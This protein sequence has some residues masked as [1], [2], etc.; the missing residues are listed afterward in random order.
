MKLYFFALFLLSFMIF[1]I[2]NCTYSQRDVLLETLKFLFV[3]N[4]RSEFSLNLLSHLLFDSLIKPNSRA[5]WIFGCVFVWQIVFFSCFFG[6]VHVH[7][8]H[9]LQVLLLISA[10]F[11]PTGHKL[12]AIFFFFATTSLINSQRSFHLS[13]H[14]RVIN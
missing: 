8:C 1:L 11:K 10:C 3:M 4:N 9:Q 13:Y 6:K 2:R 14:R 12:S 5:W 7:T